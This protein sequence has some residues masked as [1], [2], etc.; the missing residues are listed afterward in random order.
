LIYYSITSYLIYRFDT[1]IENMPKISAF[2]INQL[3]VSILHFILIISQYFANVER[4]SFTN[5]RTIDR[6]I[7][8]VTFL[9]GSILIVWA[10]KTG[11]GIHLIRSAFAKFIVLPQL[12]SNFHRLRFVDTTDLVLMIILLVIFCLEMHPI[13]KMWSK[14]LC[15][16]VPVKVKIIQMRNI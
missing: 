1:I 7:Y 5:L 12:F 2:S 9:S 10:H 14:Y 15:L 11:C 16:I 4:S 6:V 3:I 8:S 13:L